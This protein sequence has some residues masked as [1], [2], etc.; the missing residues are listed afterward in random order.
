MDISRFSRNFFSPLSQLLSFVSITI[1]KC[2]MVHIASLFLCSLSETRSALCEYLKESF[3][4]P[5]IFNGSILNMNVSEIFKRGSGD[6]KCFGHQVSLSL[7]EAHARSGSRPSIFVRH[8]GS[9][10][11]L[12]PAD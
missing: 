8:G 1:L 9:C 7:S 6:R 5:Y 3:Q 11:R 10:C 4:P 2:R 12:I